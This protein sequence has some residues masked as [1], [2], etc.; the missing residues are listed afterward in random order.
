M[1]TGESVDITDLDVGVALEGVALGK[2]I[3]FR[4]TPVK[5]VMVVKKKEQNKEIAMK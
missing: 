3:L 1:A 2:Q 4:V 5:M